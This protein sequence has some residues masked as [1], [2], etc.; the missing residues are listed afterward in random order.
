M[1]IGLA[2][3]H[4]DDSFP[5]G[6]TATIAGVLDYARR[7]EALGFDSVWVSDHLF[8]DLSKYG[9]PARRLGSPE[10][11]AMM[12]AIAGA[13]ARVRIGS[14][15]L[16]APFRNARVLAAQA[17]ALDDLA[18]GRIE[19]GIGSGWYEPEFAEAGIPFGTAGSRIAH[20]AEYAR[21]L[22]E[23]VRVPILIG[24]KGGPKIASIV[25]ESADGWNVV[26]KLTPADYRARLDVLGAACV[27][28][29]RDLASV[30]KSAGFYTLVGTSDA[31]LA[32]RYEKMR[33]FTPGLLDAVSLDAFAEGTLTG[34]PDAVAAKIKEFEALGVEDVILTFG[35]SPFSLYD[36]EQL[37]IA[38]RELLPL[39]R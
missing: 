33:A 37:D 36:D 15:V 25:A 5:D 2:L 13:T 8:L 3:P 24:G 7:A 11:L 38:A 26:W 22:R 16:C 20:L 12:T 10:A 1:K 34:T 23:H 21:T 35:P 39:V 9:G 14:L 28:A 32:A 29:G 17:T 19:L 4:Y 6:R 27:R 31:D 30:R 18:H